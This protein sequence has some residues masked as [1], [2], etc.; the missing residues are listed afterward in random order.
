MFNSTSTRTSDERIVSTSLLLL[1]IPRLREL[2]AHSNI[3]KACRV[4]GENRAFFRLTQVVEFHGFVDALPLGV[5][6]RVIA[7]IHKGFSA[8]M[9]DQVTQIFLL[10]V[11]AQKTTAL[12]VLHGIF[13]SHRQ[14]IRRLAPTGFEVM[15]AAN[16]LSV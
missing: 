4:V 12:N 3:I 9:I 11:A 6:V 14:Q 16:A 5:A 7:R 1:V 10:V 2:A 13:R 8:E 15:A